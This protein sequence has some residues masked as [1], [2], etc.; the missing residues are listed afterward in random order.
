MNFVLY[1]K[2]KENTPYSLQAQ[3]YNSVDDSILPGLDRSTNGYRKKKLQVPT[4][5][6]VGKVPIPRTPQKFTRLIQNMLLDPQTIV[7]I[8]IL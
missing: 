3:L 1:E 5:I 6:R 8:A 4:L 7:A 2:K